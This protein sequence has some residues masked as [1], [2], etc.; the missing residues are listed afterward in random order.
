MALDYVTIGAG[1]PE[2]L[3]FKIYKKYRRYTNYLV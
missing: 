2:Q 3:D 1:V